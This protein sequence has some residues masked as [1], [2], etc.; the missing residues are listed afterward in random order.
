M[1][2]DLSGRLG[3]INVGLERYVFSDRNL[4]LRKR[5]LGFSVL[6]LEK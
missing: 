1:V 6:K 3:N 4:P 2:G 5:F